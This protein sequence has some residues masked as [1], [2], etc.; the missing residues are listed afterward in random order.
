MQSSCT[1][2]YFCND[3]IEHYVKSLR[4]K[5]VL[6]MPRVPAIWLVKVGTNL[7][8]VEILALESADFIL[9][10]WQVISPWQ[11]FGGEEG[12]Q[13]LCVYTTLAKPNEHPKPQPIKVIYRNPKAPPTKQQNNCASA[14]TLNARILRVTMVLHL[15]FGYIISL[16]SRIQTQNE[17]YMITILCFPKCSCP[18]F[19]EIKLSCLDK[20]ESWANYKHLYYIFKVIY[21]L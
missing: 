3:N 15:G 6:S 9:P 13:L 20:H 7:S 16:N 2:F 8:K 5:W 19:K 4:Y 11:L 10:Q 17:D 12:I 14:F 1:E 18:N 21:N